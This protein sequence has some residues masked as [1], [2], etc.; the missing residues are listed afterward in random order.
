M[1]RK[2]RDN[3]LLQLVRLFLID[4]VR[5]LT[6]TYSSTVFHSAFSILYALQKPIQF[7]FLNGMLHD[8]MLLAFALRPL[9]SEVGA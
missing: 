4:E 7:A 5:H 1:T 2:W 8:G 9:F 3:C 6:K